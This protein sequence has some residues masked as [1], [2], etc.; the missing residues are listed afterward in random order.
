MET[1]QRM[2]VVSGMRPTGRLH[3][4]HLVG[5]LE[6]WVELQRNNDVFFEIADVHAFTTGFDEPQAIRDVREHVVL[7]W[8]SAGVDPSQ[9]TIFLQSATPEIL[10]MQTLLSMIVPLSW[11][12]RIPTYK[13]QIE[14]LGTEISTYGFLGYPLLQ[15]CDIAAFRGS[16]VPVG[17]DQLAHLEVGREI[18]RRFNHLYGPT[19]VEPEAATLRVPGRSRHRRSQDVEVLSQHDRHCRR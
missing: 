6:Q 12:Q 5:T 11:L 16:R 19:L 17:R 1:L 2:R 14:A 7:D 9:A 4:G 3:I 8:L 10:E 18:V 13:D 15:L